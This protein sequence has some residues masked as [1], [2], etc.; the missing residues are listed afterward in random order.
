MT[1][2]TTAITDTIPVATAITDTIP[3]AIST[4]S[5]GASHTGLGIY[6][7]GFSMHGNYLGVSHSTIK[8]HNLWIQHFL[9]WIQRYLSTTIATSITDG[10]TA[11]YN[12]ITRR[13]QCII[14]SQKQ[15]I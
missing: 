14:L 9:L 3:V 10:N 12:T 1:T 2:V 11:M 8:T 6:E 5:L 13:Q 7:Y 4:R 15:G